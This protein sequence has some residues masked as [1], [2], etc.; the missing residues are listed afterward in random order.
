VSLSVD[1][2]L[3][4]TAARGADGRLTIGGC[5][6]ADV[7]AEFGTSVMLLDEEG[8]RATGR[9]FVDALRAGLPRADVHFASKA[10]P[11]PAVTGLFAQE[12]LGCDVS[13]AGELAIAL[14]G[15]VPAEHIL[16][17]GNAK[18]D[19]DLQAALDAHVGLIVIDSFDEIDR[20]ER[21]T[22]GAGGRRQP[23]LV[24]INPNVFAQTHDAMA[25]GHAGSKFGI[26]GDQVADA[27]A[28][29]RKIAG[30]E[31]VGLH[32][33]VGSQ[34]LDL[35]PFVRCVE[36]IAAFGE[37][38]T[39][40]IGGGL[41]VRYTVDEPPAPSIADYATT[42]A[43]AVRAH[44][45]ADKRIIV[46][47]GRSLVAPS[48]VTAYTVVSVKRGERTFV[49]V[50]GGMGDNLEVSLYGQPFSPTILDADD[51]EP[52][53]CDLVGHHCE[54]G[55]QLATDVWL[56]RPVVDDIALVPV[57]GAYCYT[58]SNNYNGYLR[59]PVVFLR[60]GE[61]RAVVRRETI[62][63]LLRRVV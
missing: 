59:P 1:P 10:F 37:F 11:C 29:V 31:L 55:D 26:P 2:V 63:D 42:I 39:Y 7:V 12:G 38:D 5:V 61:A 49:A 22:A 25:T 16:V 62:E 28:R 23:V 50:D 32:A 48:V 4:P 52:E 43:T 41:G 19:V 8:M 14:A 6:V 44:L 46:E 56:G 27:I 13:S 20:L 47:P 40:D 17:H 3:P 54:S 45:G 35:E 9:A 30:L 53:R 57:T 36:R 33:H 21:L 60:D 58:M 18:R 15:G 24:R 51:R 34:I